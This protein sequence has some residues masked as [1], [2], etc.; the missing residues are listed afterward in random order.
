[1]RVRAC[2]SRERVARVCRMCVKRTPH[3]HLR[4]VYGPGPT[5]ALWS[6]RSAHA[7]RDGGARPS[8]ARVASARRLESSGRPHI[9]YMQWSVF[10]L[11]PFGVSAHAYAHALAIA[12]GWAACVCR[13]CVER[14]PHPHLQGVCGPGPTMALCS[15]RSAHA[16]R[17]G[18]VPRSPAVLR[19]G[20]HRGAH[21]RGMCRF[22]GAAELCQKAQLASA[23]VALLWH[24]GNQ[25]QGQWRGRRLYL[26]ALRG[27]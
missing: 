7:S 5:M 22:G 20:H 9:L 6:S 18:G 15:N 1:M 14:T 17:D 16:S 23:R 21:A 4:G 3:P 27:L 25:P 24:Q 2:V 11:G 10:I 19:H 8:V 12:R 13:M 26:R